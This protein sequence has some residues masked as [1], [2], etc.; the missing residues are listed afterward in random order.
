MQHYLDFVFLVKF[1]NHHG[2]I[3]IS[4]RGVKHPSHGIAVASCCNYIQ[5]GNQNNSHLLTA[6]TRVE[7][8]RFG[9]GCSS[10]S[11]LA[12]LVPEN[13]LWRWRI[14]VGGVWVKRSK[15]GAGHTEVVVQ[16]SV[17]LTGRRVAV[18]VVTVG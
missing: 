18:R 13:I 5:V 1:L 16:R 2:D 17:Q 3:P 6:L 11:N 7:K 9:G 15:G 14:R 8:H 4:A 10:C 12:L